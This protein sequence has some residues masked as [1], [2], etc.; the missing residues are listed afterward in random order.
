[1]RGS[2]TNVT[3]FDIWLVGEPGEPELFPW[4][5]S[6]KTTN[7]ASVRVSLILRIPYLSYTHVK[8]NLGP[9]KTKAK[10][11]LFVLH[12]SPT[13]YISSQ[14]LFS[15]REG[16]YYLLAGFPKLLIVA[17]LLQARLEDAK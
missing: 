11:S 13:L 8:L 3:P 10:G 6:S 5:N 17:H 7:T 9:I 15:P 1:V 16:V 14:K 12:S 2:P 4:H